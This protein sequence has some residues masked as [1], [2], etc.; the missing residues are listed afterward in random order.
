MGA[1]GGTSFDAAMSELAVPAFR[2]ALRIL[3]NVPDAEDVAAEAL[4]RTLRSWDRVRDLPY[5]KAW[6]VRVASNLAVDRARRR[7]PQLVA[8]EHVPDLAEA[9]TLRMALGAAM[10]AL[11]RRQAQVVAMRYLAGL[12]EAEVA[13][14]L[15]ISRNSVK[16]HAQRALAA[17]RTRL[18]TQEADLALE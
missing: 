14:S 6:V 16:T 11:P 10:Q 12:T 2:V 13:Q 1:D 5:R 18:G 4:A 15:G 8:P 17:L 9:L 3:G 7:P